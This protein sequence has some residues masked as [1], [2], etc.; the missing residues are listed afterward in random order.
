MGAQMFTTYAKGGSAKDAFW[1]A[2]N[3]ALAE[4]GNDGY[5]GT[6]AE[7]AEFV[8]IDLPP[9]ET[10]DERARYLLINNDPR[11]SDKWGPAGCIDCGDGT[12]LFFGSASS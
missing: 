2:V 6:M 3:D 10:P 1:H 11:I 5:T 4:Y 7:K 8:M 9:G 12:F